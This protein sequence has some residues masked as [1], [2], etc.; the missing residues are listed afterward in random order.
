[1]SNY[2]STLST[3]IDEAVNTFNDD[4][5]PIEGISYEKL[6]RKRREQWDEIIDS[7]LIEW[8]KNP[9]LLEDPDEGVL[10]P[11]NQ[12]IRIAIG[13]A[14]VMRNHDAIPPSRVV[15]DGEGGIAFELM[16][17][18]VFESMQVHSDCSVELLTF[19]N[20]RLLARRPI[21]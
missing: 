11:T 8:G 1:M 13:L 10:S 18:E 14:L 16:R 6:R 20:C 21:S 4:R 3:A 12:S 17:G 7:F 2:S 19:R 5:T 15:P 9:S